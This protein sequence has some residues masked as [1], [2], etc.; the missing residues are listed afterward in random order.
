MAAHGESQPCLRPTP[1]ASSCTIP[2]VHMFSMVPY[3]LNITAVHPSGSSSSSFVT[4][5]P[6][7]ISEWGPWLGGEEGHWLICALPPL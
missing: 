4:F 1:E 2:D 6:E 5:V 7:H 3:L